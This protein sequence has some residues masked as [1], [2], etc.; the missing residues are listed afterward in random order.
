ML[1]VHYTSSLI[2]VLREDGGRIGYTRAGDVGKRAS[3]E[4]LAHYYAVDPLC[5]SAG[6]SHNR[7]VRMALEGCPDLS[8]AEL[9]FR[10]KHYPVLHF[11]DLL[12][13]GSDEPNEVQKRGILGIYD[14][15]LLV[16]A[17]NYRVGRR[18]GGVVIYYGGRGGDAAVDCL[19][20]LLLTLVTC[21]DHHGEKIHPVER[22]GHYS[23]DW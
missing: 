16:Q 17:M 20:W 12:L 13:G 21:Q 2:A 9:T 15:E 14:S 22:G 6:D 3:L 4:K 7:A 10:A 23:E 1:T 18:E 8:V 19:Q 5:C 11:V